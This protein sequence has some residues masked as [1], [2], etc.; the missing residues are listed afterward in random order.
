MSLSR[1][2]SALLQL[3]VGPLLWIAPAKADMRIEAAKITAGDLWVLGNAG[4]PDA[5]ITLDGKF[6]Q[7]TDTR[8]YF[9][10]H[11]V[12]HPAT[13]IATL[14]TSKQARSIVVGECGQQALGLPGPPG[15]RGEAG[16]RGE[17]G[18]PGAMGPPGTP[19]TDGPVGA[20][21]ERGPQGP[22]GP[23]GSA[24]PA[25]PPGP[26]G[27]QGAPGPT[28]KSAPSSAAFKAKPSPTLTGSVTRPR[29]TRPQQE[30]GQGPG[31]AAP[32]E[33]G[34]GV[35]ADDRY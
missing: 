30:P 13:C 31:D 34:A 22:E 35:A 19:G 9:E 3:F 20:Q 10:F 21:G 4:E 8:G 26:R 24:G 12:Y 15:P 1:R 29:A 33:P 2:Q 17:P 18:R 6:S 14:R 25:G 16:I 7:R 5:E 28:G 11:V 32:S 23:V 27:P